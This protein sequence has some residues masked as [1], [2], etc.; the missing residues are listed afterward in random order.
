M[1][2]ALPPRSPKLPRSMKNGCGNRRPQ[3]E[4]FFPSSP[5]RRASPD[6]AGRFGWHSGQ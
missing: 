6:Y 1:K 3:V 2:S 4:A 5:R